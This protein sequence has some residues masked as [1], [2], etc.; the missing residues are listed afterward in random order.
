MNYGK[1]Y[2]QEYKKY[3]GMNTLQ[4]CEKVEEYFY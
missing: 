4:H 3:M 2:T 1:L